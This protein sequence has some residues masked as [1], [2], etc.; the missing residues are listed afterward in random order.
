MA[1][2]AQVETLTTALEIRRQEE[3]RLSAEFG[4]AL[5]IATDIMSVNAIISVTRPD[6]LMTKSV[7]QRQIEAYPFN[8]HRAGNFIP[9]LGGFG[10]LRYANRPEWPGEKP[11]RTLVGRYPV[12]DL[13]FE[14]YL[15]LAAR[16]SREDYPRFAM[17]Q[18]IDPEIALDAFDNSLTRYGAFARMTLIAQSLTKTV[19]RSC[20]KESTQP[21]GLEIYIAYSLASLLVDK[22][23]YGVKGPDDNEVLSR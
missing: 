5:E 9:R 12:T 23:D 21:R 19:I 7:P 6:L 2:L 16:G 22:N 3:D 18:E 15:T 10:D 14:T 11:T 17:E 13:G 4:E 20:T 8:H 1:R